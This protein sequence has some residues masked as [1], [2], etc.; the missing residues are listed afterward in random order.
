MSKT[1]HQ[2]TKNAHSLQPQLPLPVADAEMKV[3]LC[4]KPRGVKGFPIGAWVDQNIAMFALPT[5]RNFS[6]SHFYLPSPFN[7]IFSKSSFHFFLALGVANLGSHVGLWSKLGHPAHCPRWLMQEHNKASVHLQLLKGV[8]RQ[9]CVDG[10]DSEC[11]F[12]LRSGA[13][14][15]LTVEHIVLHC[16]DSTD[17]RQKPQAG[18]LRTLFKKTAWKICLQCFKREIPLT[19]CEKMECCIVYFII[20]T[21]CAYV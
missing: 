5:A 1:M 13:T 16:T 3:T 11:D 4:W 8:H 7:F 17:V 20:S 6:L 2:M 18:S 9:K 19:S 12:H 14:W 15:W 10:T 21:I